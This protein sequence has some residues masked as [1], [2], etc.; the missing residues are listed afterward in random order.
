M[1]P[2]GKEEAHGELAP[3]P[4]ERQSR[5]VNIIIL[6]VNAI[7]EMKQRSPHFGFPPPRIYQQGVSRYVSS[8]NRSGI[9][10]CNHS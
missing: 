5:P 3:P 6:L 9:Q 7:V 8:E 2:A 4:A 1:A 10:A